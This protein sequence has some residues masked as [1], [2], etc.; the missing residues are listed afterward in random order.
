MSDKMIPNLPE[1]DNRETLLKDLSYGGFYGYAN[2][3][4]MSFDFP[5]T[6]EFEDAALHDVMN[7]SYAIAR[8]EA[9]KIFEAHQKLSVNDYEMLKL[10]TS[11]IRGL[12]VRAYGLARTV[13]GTVPVKYI[14]VDFCDQMNALYN[15][16]T[17]LGIEVEQ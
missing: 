8:S 10:Y 12:L 5:S 2:A 6:L 9:E 7:R 13:W 14:T 11:K 15:E 16:M 4:G 1:N 3:R 17:E